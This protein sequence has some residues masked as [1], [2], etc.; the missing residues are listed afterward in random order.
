MREL[1][2]SKTSMAD[3][4]TCQQTSNQ[5]RIAQVQDAARGSSA[6]SSAVIAEN[7]KMLRRFI[8]FIPPYP[9][10]PARAERDRRPWH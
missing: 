3:F 5:G 2:A 9:M 10:F 8:L 6:S 7:V 1:T 4:A